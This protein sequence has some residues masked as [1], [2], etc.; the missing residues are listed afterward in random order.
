MVI[1]VHHLSGQ[2]REFL[3]SK[4]NFNINIYISEEKKILD[5]GRKKVGNKKVW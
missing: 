1:N 5:T 4:K 3:K 2:I